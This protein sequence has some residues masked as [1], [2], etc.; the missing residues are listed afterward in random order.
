MPPLGIMFD[1]FLGYKLFAMI[2]PSKHNAKRLLAKLLKAFLRKA[3]TGQTIKGLFVERIVLPEIVLLSM[4]ADFDARAL[5]VEH[6]RQ[7][8]FLKLFG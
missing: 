7:L 1:Q 8:F 6:D 4:R 2:K 3:I 5:D